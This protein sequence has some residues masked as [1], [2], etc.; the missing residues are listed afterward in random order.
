MHV[1]MMHSVAYL[2]DLITTL[3]GI[4]YISECTSQSKGYILQIAREYIICT[5]MNL[6]TYSKAN[7]SQCWLVD[8][9]YIAVS[10]WAATGFLN[11]YCNP[12]FLL[13]PIFCNILFVYF[14]K[15]IATVASYLY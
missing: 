12:Y 13:N 6:A 15:N 1:Q 9:S 11:F 10:N 3:A 7:S 5:Y 4:K 2:Q 14:L 8:D